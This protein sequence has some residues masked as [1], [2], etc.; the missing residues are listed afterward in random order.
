MGYIFIFS[1]NICTAPM[2][3]IG[4]QNIIHKLYCVKL[5]PFTEET[6]I[7]NFPLFVTY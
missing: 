1:Q 5:N 2:Y 3:L 4:F 7:K 6:N